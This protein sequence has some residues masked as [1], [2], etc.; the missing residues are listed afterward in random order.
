[1]ELYLHAKHLLKFPGALIFL[2]LPFMALAQTE[3]P[4]LINSKLEGIV[5][6]SVTK[7]PIAGVSLRIKNITHMVI[8]GADGR[9]AF[10]TG[11]KFPYTLV[12]TFVGYKTKEVVADG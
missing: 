1:M 11:Q 8:T 3:S 5:T 12:V 7:Q 9:F 10:V 4:P 2:L 6:D